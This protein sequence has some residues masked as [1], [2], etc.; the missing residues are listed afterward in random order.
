MLDV[1]DCPDPAASAPRRNATTTPLQAL[2]LWN[3]SFALRMSE[4][5]AANAAAETTAS[6]DQIACVYRTVLQREPTADELAAAAALVSAHGLRS[7]C[8]ALVNSNEF[9]TLP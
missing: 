9:L 7:L 4:Q 6:S 2:S 5:I 3:G 1:F 8:R